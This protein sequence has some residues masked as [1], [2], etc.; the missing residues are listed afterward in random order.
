MAGGKDREKKKNK[1]IGEEE[2]ER[3]T[4]MGTTAKMGLPSVLVVGK[5]REGEGSRGGFWCSNGL[6]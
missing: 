2:R 3:V 5:L 6:K 4:A 1:K